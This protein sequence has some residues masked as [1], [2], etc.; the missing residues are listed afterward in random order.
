MKGIILQRLVCF[1]VFVI[2]YIFREA[3]IWFVPCLNFDHKVIFHVF[4]LQKQGLQ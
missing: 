3:H 2:T 1:E 4:I